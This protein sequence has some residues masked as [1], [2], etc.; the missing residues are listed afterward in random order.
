MD[1]YKHLS[2]LRAQG[3]QQTSIK[4]T[5]TQLTFIVLCNPIKR[6][7]VPISKWFLSHPLV[8]TSVVFHNGLGVRVLE[9]NLIV[10]NKS[11]TLKGLQQRISHNNIQKHQ[12]AIIL[13]A[14]TYNRS[15]RTWS[16]KKYR[17]Q[18]D[19]RIS[20]GWIYDRSYN[21]CSF[22]QIWHISLNHLQKQTKSLP[23]FSIPQM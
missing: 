16:N 20:W 17:H 18:M 10:N 9:R 22:N 23:R 6:Q 14:K 12:H 4:E 2:N 15:C 19:I 3:E 21:W 8:Q 11:A 5:L 7:R 13:F 1:A